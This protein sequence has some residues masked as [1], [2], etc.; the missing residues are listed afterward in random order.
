MDINT[1]KVLKYNRTKIQKMP[2][3]WFS[4]FP[5]CYVIWNKLFNIKIVINWLLDPNK[6]AKHLQFSSLRILTI[7]SILVNPESDLES[8]ILWT[9]NTKS[10][11]SGTPC[12]KTDAQYSLY[13]TCFRYWDVPKQLRLV[14]AE[15]S[16][17]GNI[18]EFFNSK[19][20]RSSSQ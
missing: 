12:L 6:G 15:F 14:L 20:C 3:F 16:D 9:V 18:L 4:N 17:Q 7:Q 2:M 13:E 8:E 19:L 5:T 11:F 1:A 10:S